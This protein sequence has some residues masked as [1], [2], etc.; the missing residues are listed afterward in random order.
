MDKIPQGIRKCDCPSCGAHHDRD[1]NAAINILREEAS[2]LGIGNTRLEY[3]N[4]QEQL[5]F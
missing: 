2:S 1:H 3:S 5:P 4:I